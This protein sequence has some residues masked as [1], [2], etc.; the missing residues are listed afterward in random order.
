MVLTATR[1][2]WGSH[3]GV[4]VPAQ[5]VG[6]A[7]EAIAD[8]NGVCTPSDLVGLARPKT[9][10]LH[11]AFEWDNRAAADNWR[12][13]EA[14]LII[15][16]VRCIDAEGQ[17]EQSPAFVHVQVEGNGEGYAPLSS[18]LTVPYQHAFVLEEALAVLQGFRRRYESISGLEPVWK[19]LDEITTG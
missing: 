1:Y 9:H 2:V 10:P 16:S 11:P 13:H 15:G 14:R 17:A 3:G 5:I 7:V 4:G 8:R 18:V 12:I 6:E 19:A